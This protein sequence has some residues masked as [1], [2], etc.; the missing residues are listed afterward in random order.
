MNER[1]HPG[2][3][4]PPTGEGI[5]TQ[6]GRDEKRIL[7]GFIQSLKIILMDERI[8]TLGEANSLVP[9][10][11]ALLREVQQMRRFV[12][13]IRGEIQKARDNV[14]ANGG[15][16]Q[17]PSYLKALEYIM[18]RVE[19]IQQM[20]VMIKDLEKGLCDFP[21]MLDGRMVYLCW[22]LGEAEVGWWHETDTG[23]LNR[24]PLTEES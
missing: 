2:G 5:L 10:L 9:D 7:T 8:F 6:T 18:K 21:F 11:E 16:P 22:K 4:N 13:Q 24:K 3:K 20:G 1:V 15:S 14:S 17:G 23:Y 19:R 12:L